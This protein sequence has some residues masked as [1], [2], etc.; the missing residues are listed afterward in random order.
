L[1]EVKKDSYLAAGMS[2]CCTLVVIILMVR[3][4]RVISNLG[5]LGVR[6]QPYFSTFFE[7]SVFAMEFAWRTTQMDV[8]GTAEWPS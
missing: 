8:D 1:Q 5:K 3:D 6:T 7:T 4:L 2:S